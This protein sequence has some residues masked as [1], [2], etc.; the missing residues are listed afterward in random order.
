MSLLDIFKKKKDAQTT[1]NTDP[2]EELGGTVVTG[3]PPVEEG[4]DN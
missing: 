4:D 1:I 3:E 2:I